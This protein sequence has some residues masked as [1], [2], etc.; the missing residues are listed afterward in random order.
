MIQWMGPFEYGVGVC[1][2]RVGAIN[3]KARSSY[4]VLV[5]GP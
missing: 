1:S 4:R 3:E 5:R 2:Q